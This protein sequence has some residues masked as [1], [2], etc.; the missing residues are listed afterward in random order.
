MLFQADSLRKDAHGIVKVWP[1]WYPSLL[2]SA[3]LQCDLS[4]EL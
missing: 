1:V 2:R 4:A 3:A